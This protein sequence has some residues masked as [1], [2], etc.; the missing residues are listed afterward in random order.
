MAFVSIDGCSLEQHRV[1][2]RKDALALFGVG[3]DG[4]V[5]LL[6]K[7]TGI[8]AIKVI[9]YAVGIASRA[10]CPRKIQRRTR[11]KPQ[12]SAQREVGGGAFVV[13]IEVSTIVASN[14]ACSLKGEP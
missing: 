3:N 4:A 12:T 1:T 9:Q 14:S 11:C 2:H 8:L 5:D 7:T 13:F 10:G 6:S